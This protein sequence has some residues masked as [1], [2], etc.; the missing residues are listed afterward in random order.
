VDILNPRTIRLGLTATDKEHA[1]RLAG[2]LLVAEKYVAPQYVLGMLAREKIASNYLGHG[3][4]IPHG[5]QEDLKYV[6]QTG[7]SFVQLPEGVAWEAGERT[8]AGEKAYLVLGLA[9]ASNDLSAILSNLLEVL[10]NP[11]IIQQL[12]QTDDPQLIIATLAGRS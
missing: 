11:T 12:V 7:V 2:Q 5:R 4:A 8:F 3:I 9:A 10:R 6:Y 1:I